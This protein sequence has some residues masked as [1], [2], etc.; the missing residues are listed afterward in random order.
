MFIGPYNLVISS[1]VLQNSS[2]V[3]NI[4]DPDS[5]GSATFRV[6]LSA[7]GQEPVSHFGTRTMLE[8]ATVNAL[9]NMSTTEFK[10]YIDQVS[11]QR[12]RAPVGSVTAFKNSLQMDNGTTF[13]AFI[14]SLGL[15]RIR[16]SI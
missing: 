14:A 16:V 6:R 13:D 12:G 11:A 15:Q 1:G 3:F 2:D 10:A 9:Q 7:N 5:G 4:L 8:E